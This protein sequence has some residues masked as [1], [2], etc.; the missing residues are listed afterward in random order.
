VPDR[1]KD[2]LIVVETHDGMARAASREL[3]SIGRHLAGV[4]GGRLVAAV[5]GSGTHEAVSNVAGLG[6]DRVL[7]ADHPELVRVTVDGYAKAIAAAVDVA[8][9]ATVLLAG[10]TAGRDIAAFLSARYRAG[11]LVDCLRLVCSSDEIVGTRAVSGGRFLVEVRAS[12]DRLT[13]ATVQ[14]GAYPVPEPEPGRTV[15]AE[16]LDIIFDA[17]E[18]R[19]VILDLSPPTVGSTGLDAAENVVV[20][21]RGVGDAASFRLV[22]DLAAVVDAAVGATGAVTDLG[23]RPRADQVGQTGRR[24]APRLYIGLGVSGA[25]QHLAGMRESET[26]VAINLDPA[27]PIFKIAHFGIVGDLFEVVPAL[28]ERLRQEKGR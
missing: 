11:C 17:D 2:I 13:F 16:S 9:P 18:I 4:T 21:G 1:P 7:V 28:I 5:I 25:V 27:A 20:G 6:A 24:I 19:T 10:T 3:F 14:A 26:I 8:E 15:R 23:W 22:E 12:R